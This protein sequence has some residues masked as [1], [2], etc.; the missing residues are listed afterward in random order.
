[1][2]FAFTPEAPRRFSLIRPCSALLTLGPLGPFLSRARIYTL[3]RGSALDIYRTL[4]ILPTAR[5]SPIEGWALPGLKL[6]NCRQFWP[7]IVTTPTRNCCFRF[8]S[9]TVSHGIA[10]LAWDRRQSRT[11]LP[12]WPGIGGTLARN[13]RSGLLSLPAPHG[14]AAPA[15]GRCSEAPRNATPETR[16]EAPT[17]SHR[18]PVPFGT[19]YS[20]GRPRQWEV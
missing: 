10:V 9:A 16:P 18:Q 11:E 12:L 2:L 17:G 3:P 6:C 15:S 8:G 4:N 19:R 7:A 13:C 20:T 14:M 5:R 1:M